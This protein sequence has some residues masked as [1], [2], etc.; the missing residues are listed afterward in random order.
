MANWYDDL[1]EVWDAVW[2]VLERGVAERSAPARHPVLA[3]AGLEGGAEARVVVL[4]AASRD[5]AVLEVHTDSASGKVGEL[6]RDP[7][8]TLLVWDAE[9]RLQIRVR[10]RVEIMKGAG[11]ARVWDRLPEGSRMV[12]GVQPRPGTIIAAPNAFEPDA[13]PARFSVLTARAIEFDIVY[14]GSQDH[15][16]VLYRAAAN[17][18]GTWLAP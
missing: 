15:R 10:A 3:T 17:W 11:A 16:R 2:R 14:L 6:T 7:A 18:H 1:D 5:D 12:Y 13:N 8:A 4:R 9:E